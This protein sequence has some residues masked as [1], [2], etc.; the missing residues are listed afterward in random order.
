MESSDAVSVR[1]LTFGTVALAPNFKSGSIPLQRKCLCAVAN[2]GGTICVLAY[3][4]R[5]AANAAGHQA[6]QLYRRHVEN[7]SWR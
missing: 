3:I 2:I 4:Q 7:L 5:T 6:L 1:T